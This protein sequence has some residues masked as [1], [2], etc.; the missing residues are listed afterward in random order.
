MPWSAP[1]APRASRVGE[2]GEPL[3]FQALHQPRQG[4]D[5]F[6]P[7]AI[8]QPTNSLGGQLLERGHQRC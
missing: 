4:Q 8:G 7:A 1:A 2:V 5:P 6:G 3:A